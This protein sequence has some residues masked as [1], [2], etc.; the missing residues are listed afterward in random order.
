MLA[1][2]FFKLVPSSPHHHLAHLCSTV[3]ASLRKLS[4]E[5]RR[6]LRRNTRHLL[7]KAQLDPTIVLLALYYLRRASQL[8]P[9]HSDDPVSADHQILAALICAHKFHEDSA[10]TNR[11]WSEVSNVPLATINILERSF[12]NRLR[13]HLAVTSF[14]AY[15]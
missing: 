13:H 3:V 6:L 10:Y 2:V 5:P 15:L 4:D 12:L 9:S 8:S 11:T 14:K 1:P 7:D